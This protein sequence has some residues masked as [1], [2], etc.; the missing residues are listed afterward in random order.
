M[1]LI[2]AAL[3]EEVSGILRAGNAREVPTS[4]GF[5]AF[6]GS[7]GDESSNSQ[8]T[9]VVS[10]TGPLRAKQAVEWA[11]DNVADAT[12]LV[13]GFAG[14]TSATLGRGDLVIPTM[15]S[16]IE[17]SPINWESQRMSGTLT[18]DPELMTCARIAV[19]V[20]GVGSSSGMLVSL[21][22][23]ARTSNMKSW[24]GSR[25]NASAVDLESHA[26]CSV[27][28]EAGVP[29]VVARSVVDAIDFDLPQLVADIPGGSSDSRV[30]PTIKY[31]ARRPWQLTTV[32]DLRDAAHVARDNLTSFCRE[33][34]NQVN[35][36]GARA[37]G[38]GAAA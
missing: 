23:I 29:F 7:Y 37:P 27:A 30:W 38:S 36:V 34:S 33:F 22:S 8:F 16:T 24:I 31:V 32:F 10:G 12:L 15:V 11:I 13:I 1:L 21:P 19:E 5:R 18:P 20:A 14:G 6:Y 26:V 3:Q 28:S 9:V 17:G 25:L 4:H 2:L 35:G